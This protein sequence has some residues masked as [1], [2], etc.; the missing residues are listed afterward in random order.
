VPVAVLSDIHGNFEALER[1]L[2]VCDDRSL[3]EV[4]CLGDVVGYGADPGACVDLV[5][6]K[7]ALTCAGNHDWAASGRIDTSNFNTM[8]AAA[9]TWTQAELSEHQTQYLDA[10]PLEYHRDDAHFVHGS[11]HDP[12]AFHY[13]FGAS[14]AASA[15]T[16]SSAALTFVGH[17][18]RAFVYDDSEGEV[19]SR[20]GTT[21]IAA[22]HRVL[23]NVGSVG[24]PRDG[25]PRAAFCV[26]DIEC[27]ALELI[28]VPYDVSVTQEKILDNGLPEFLAHRLSAGR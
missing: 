2:E 23:V 10:L 15:L 14:E 1:V 28:R 7:A 22:G 19:V 24:Q 20:E 11:P 17:S 3:V 18:H 13:I 26:W 8:A 4:L 9:I 21:Q 16:Q 27:G 12:S 6:D 25:D 5:F